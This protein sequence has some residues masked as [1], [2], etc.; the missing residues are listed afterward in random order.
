M[1]ALV[2]RDGT[3]SVPAAADPVVVLS[4]PWTAAE[5]LHR[6][7][8]ALR[9]GWP[10]LALTV[11][12]G[13]IGAVVALNAVTPVYRSTTVLLVKPQPAATV[14]D[15]LGEQAAATVRAIG[16]AQIAATL[17]SLSEAADVAGLPGSPPEL[18]MRVYASATGSDPFVTITVSGPDPGRV[19]ALAEAF[20]TS[21]PESAA[22]LQIFPGT[23]VDLLVLRAP[24][25]PR[26]VYPPTVRMLLAG[27]G[28]GLVLGVG[29]L[30][31]PALLSGRLRSWDEVEAATGWPLLAPV[32][33]SRTDAPPHDVSEAH[34]KLAVEL[35]A[36]DPPL[37]RVD[38][39]DVDRRGRDDVVGLAARLRTALVARDSSL[40]VRVVDPHDPPS[41]LAVAVESAEST[42]GRVLVLA[43]VS[44]RRLP[45]ARELRRLRH[46]LA[47]HPR[48]GAVVLDA[49]GS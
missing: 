47:G 15:R 22:A 23:S 29:L 41:A 34:R 14:S 17:P 44:A 13:L 20:T 35:T 8:A 38:V 39:V 48:V 46:A 43:V 9:R 10:L 49:Q 16:L 31:T 36:V 3:G 40:E 7:A 27:V 37:T 45:A 30:V 24:P 32:P 28:A 33:R 12:A 42:G 2:E 19:T 11:V 6:G 4:A 5:A 1:T 26:N 18:G 25:P 21:L